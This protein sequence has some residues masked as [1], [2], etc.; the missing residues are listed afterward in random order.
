MNL[1]LYSDLGDMWGIANALLSLASAES[2]HGDYTH[3]KQHLEESLALFRQC[4]DIGGIA[5]ALQA[6]GQLARARNEDEQTVVLFEESMALFRRIG[7]RGAVHAHLA[8]L[9]YMAYRR[10][11]LARMEACFR[12]G[13]VLSNEIGDQGPSALHLAGLAGALGLTGRP[14]LAARLFGAA[15]ALLDAIGQ[16]RDWLD[17]RDQDRIVAA[18]RAQLGDDTFAALCAAGRALTLEQAI[19]EALGQ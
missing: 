4:G 11:D 3:A 15:D 1:A 14:E 10:G 6:L 2:D 7:A 8:N 16:T 12:E 13:L 5:G 19:A 18:V 17:G 9:G